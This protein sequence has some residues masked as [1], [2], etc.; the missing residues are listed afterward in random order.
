MCDVKT[1]SDACRVTF[2]RR[3]A[4]SQA[5]SGSSMTS[6]ANCQNTHRSRRLLGLA[7]QLRHAHLEHCLQDSRYGVIHLFL[8]RALVN[9]T[10]SPTPLSAWTTSA[11]R[12]HG[13]GT[14]FR[15][16][17]QSPDSVAF[18]RA[19]VFCSFSLASCPLCSGEAC[20]LRGYGTPFG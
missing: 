1:S 10:S 5:V 9:Q 11:R 4:Q 8:L 2:R 7:Y 20:S 16:V 17:W 3:F 12:T 15:G 19:V 18:I 6:A 13:V 14:C